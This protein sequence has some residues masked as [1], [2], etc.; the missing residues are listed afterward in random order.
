MNRFLLA[1]VVSLLLP[2]MI[3]PASADDSDCANFVA[4]ADGSWSPTH[5]FMYATNI[6]QIQL[7]TSDKMDPKMSGSAGR[8]ARYLGSHCQTDRSTA[9]TLHIPKSP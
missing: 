3:S 8:L 9:D 4:N 6:A 2:T 1:G 7:T 5:N